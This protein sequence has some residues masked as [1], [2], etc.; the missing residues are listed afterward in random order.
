MDSAS[1]SDC[2]SVDIKSSCLSL[3][4]GFAIQVSATAHTTC[5]VVV[6]IVVI[7]RTEELLRPP[8]EGLLKSCY[9]AVLLLS[10]LSML[11]SG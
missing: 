4:L 6:V 9:E 5:K 3:A 11:A 1:F 7:A 8:L 2:W 10:I